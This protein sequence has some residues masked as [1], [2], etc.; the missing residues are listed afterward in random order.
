MGQTRTVAAHTAAARDVAWEWV[1]VSCC[2]SAHSLAAG[3]V[4]IA[5]DS[6]YGELHV[7]VRI[8]EIHRP[9]VAVERGPLVGDDIQL[10]LAVTEAV[11]A[12]HLDRSLRGLARGLVVM[13]KVACEQH[14]VCI[15]FVGNLEDL[16]ERVPRIILADRIALVYAQV[17]IRCDEDTQ[18]LRLGLPAQ[19]SRVVSQ[20]GTRGTVGVGE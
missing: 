5:V 20:D 6:E 12:K 16:L 18:H 9:V 7:V 4:V 14:Q 11:V 1:W 15:P 8:F 17:A 19:S 3:I 13:E 10:H 2:A